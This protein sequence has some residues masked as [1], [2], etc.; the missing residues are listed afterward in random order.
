MVRNMDSILPKGI[1][2]VAVNPQIS[3][4]LEMFDVFYHDIFAKAFTNKDGCESYENFLNY[5]AH[6]GKDTLY[7]HVLIF[8]NDREI[9]GGIVIDYFD[10]IKSLAIE[11]IVV[12]PQYQRQGIAGK[13]IKYT[14]AYLECK[15]RKSIEWI[16]IEIENPKFVVDNNISYLYFW[17][18]CKMKAIDF[19][20]IQPPL[21]PEKEPVEI[22]TLCAFNIS[23]DVESINKNYVKEFLTL[24]AHYAM[25]I[26]NPLQDQSIQKMFDEL[27]KSKNETLDL[28]GLTHLL[29]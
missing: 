21:S 1:E 26:G 29:E 7:V 19:S 18:K 14:K 8:Y 28:I 2:C 22:L 17:E 27:D 13:I 10:E 3:K 20:Y 11:F 5:I 9:I 12:S 23:Y 6:Y 24:Y 4:T 15:H 25:R 16:I